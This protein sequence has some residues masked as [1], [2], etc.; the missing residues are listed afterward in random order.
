MILLFSLLLV[1]KLWCFWNCVIHTGTGEG[2]YRR[3]GGILFCC[4]RYY[5]ECFVFI[6]LICFYFSVEFQF[7]SGLP[8]GLNV[9]LLDGCPSVLW[10]VTCHFSI[11]ILFLI[12]QQ[13]KRSSV[14][15]HDQ[16]NVIMLQ[17]C[18]EKEIVSKR[19]FCCQQQCTVCAEKW[20]MWEGATGSERLIESVSGEVGSAVN[21]IA[22]RTVPPQQTSSHW[23][24]H[25]CGF[26]TSRYLRSRVWLVVGK[27]SLDVRD[28]ESRVK[29][30]K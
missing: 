1:S 10:S 7:Y 27:W 28:G 18:A 11:V 21:M 8:N 25:T 15:K 9:T 14:H 22:L 5:L 3:G 16:C 26:Q 17:L 13:Q 30:G 24:R 20:R 19:Q 6:V 2:L 12:S 4:F 29:E 23:S